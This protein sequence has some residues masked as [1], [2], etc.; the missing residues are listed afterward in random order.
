MQ[1]V[2]RLDF[3]FGFACT[4]RRN[5]PNASEI[6]S[7]DGNHLANHISPPGSE[8]NVTIGALPQLCRARNVFFAETTPRAGAVASEWGPG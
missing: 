1:I 4:A 6:F 5:P 8:D 7:Y 2:L 3:G